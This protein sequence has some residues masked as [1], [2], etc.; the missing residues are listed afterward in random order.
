MATMTKGKLMDIRRSIGVMGASVLLMALVGAAPAFAESPWWQIMSVSGPRNLPPDGEGNITV[1]ATDLGDADVNGVSTP[2]TVTDQLPAGVTATAV[3]AENLSL[4]TRG[5]DKNA[6][7]SYSAHTVSCTF[8][9]VLQTYDDVEVVIRVRVE[10]GAASGEENE[11]T[12]FGGGA[13]SVSSRQPI[14]VS[15]EPTR[16]GVEQYELVPENEGGSVDTQAGSHPFQLTTTF[17]MNRAAETS[18]TPG[19]ALGRRSGPVSLELMK[20]LYFNLPP[21]LIGNP[22]PF[23]QC[24]DHAFTEQG[25]GT[26]ERGCPLDTAIGV[27]QVTV[28]EPQLEGFISEAV[29][30]YN[31]VPNMGEPARFEFTIKDVP[32]V[33]DTSVR[34]GTDYGVVVSVENISE[35]AD[36]LSSKVTFWGVPGDP[37]HDQSRGKLCEERLELKAFRGTV[38]T[39]PTPE[40]HPAPFLTLPTSCSGQWQTSV[41]ADT[42]EQ[43]GAFTSFE[44]VFE[45]SMDACNQLGFSPSISVAPDVQSASAPTGLTVGVHVPQQE[46]LNPTGVA[47][48]DVRDTTVT[49]PEGVTVNPAGANN[50]E[51]CSEAQIGFEGVEQP[52]GLDRFTADEPSCPN[53]SK[54]ATV[55]I[56][57]PLLPDPLEGEV[58][59]A[60]QSANPFGSL[61]ALYLVAEDPVAGVLIK[62][63]GE[64]SLNPV[65]GQI[66][67]TFANT[68]Q[69]PFET[70]ELHFF[71]GER[72]PLA[73]PAHCG[74]YTTNA[75]F[76]PWSGNEAVSSSGSFEITSGP[77][78]G[79][80]PGASLPFAPSF[81]AGTANVQAGAFSPFDTVLGRE[82]GN[83]SLQAVELHMP[84]GFAGLLS[85]VKLCGNE[86]ADAGTC[87][88]ES[89]IGHTTVS[90]G[91]GGDPYTVTGGE[92]FITGPYNG[93]GACTVGSP[94]CAP[95]GL[96]I[97]NP[98]V[99]GPYNLGKVVVRAKIEVNP[100]T[101]ALT[102]ATDDTGPYEIPTI[103]DG[104]PLQIKH[105]VVTV[106][107]PWF[108]INPTSCNPMQITGTLSSAEGASSAV[109][110]PFQV[111]NCGALQFAPKFAVSTSGTTSK[112]YGAS[113]TAKLSYPSAPAGTQANI[114]KVKVDLPKQLP[115][116][117]TTLQQACTNAQ[118]EANPANCPT[119]SKVGYATVT[120]PLLPV[121]LTGPAIFVSHGGESFPS[122]TMVL[123]GYG[124]TIDLVGSTFIS[125]AGITSTT[126]KSVPD[127][128]FNTFLLTL[129]EGKYSALAAN[130]DLCKSRLAMPTE[131]VAQN[132]TE[133]HE[134]TPIVVTGCRRTLTRAQKLSQAL[135][136]CKKKKKSSQVDCE[137]QARTKYGRVQKK[138]KK[139]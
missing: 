115:S 63:A 96:S 133:I 100:Q 95:F 128:P 48:G 103:L 59:L 22:T 43:A 60:A 110:V 52:S 42:W 72:A 108:T 25:E 129:P 78:G 62:V 54:I 69:L 131:F 79:P 38:C 116:R 51:A 20:D 15:T 102:I 66:T 10:P 35:A 123:Q 47:E 134:S 76:A 117:L 93:R 36:I 29:P 68:P 7:C 45:E 18:P 24:T 21:G 58:Y 89:L 56:R 85:G 1:M 5:Q 119:G 70:L 97:V 92:V 16:P 120:T 99:A 87:N 17:T 6:A 127:T 83:Q 11:A 130:G 138:A 19:L 57:S 91:L 41:E 105:I 9:E 39:S 2:F 65:T 86:Q 8:T 113:L 88:Q 74:T 53:A 55:M 90:V 82:D 37:R 139:K 104:I 106:D 81:A 137:K 121:P 75:L 136:A 30:V 107:R 34:T 46:G 49:L 111:T 50:F 27:A 71:G 61:V 12:V 3:L 73:A 132:G 126:F 125:H 44:P 28:Y 32:V 26:E 14:T 94:E 124:V 4:D 112:A 67:T 109:H 122:L 23:P 135:K 77:N 118:F 40:A 33:L 84:P 101:A 114:A 80:C 98:A 31:M 13:P 64:V